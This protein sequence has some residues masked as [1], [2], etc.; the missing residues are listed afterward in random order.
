MFLSTCTILPSV[1]LSHFS[2]TRGK[3]NLPPHMH[4][5]TE[6]S[7][8]GHSSALSLDFPLCLSVWILLGVIVLIFPVVPSSNPLPFACPLGASPRLLPVEAQ[9]CVLSPVAQRGPALPFCI[10]QATES[11][12]RQHCQVSAL[13]TREVGQ[14]WGRMSWIS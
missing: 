14:G 6:N 2:Q 8:W 10:W 13:C 7:A 3:C 12:D 11:K 4:L 5:E 9:P 1:S